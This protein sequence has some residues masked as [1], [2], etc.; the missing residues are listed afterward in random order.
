MNDEE[1][2]D[3]VRLREIYLQ[4]L[5]VGPFPT[6]ECAAARTKGGLHGDLVM[7]LA[8]IAGIASRRV[9]LTTL[10]EPRRLEFQ[11]TFDHST[12]YP[13]NVKRLLTLSSG[14]GS[15]CTNISISVVVYG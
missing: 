6:S 5:G 7:Y 13:R 11:G 14:I 8:N 10:E 9:K 4:K 3:L 12:H 1:Q 2:R 15:L